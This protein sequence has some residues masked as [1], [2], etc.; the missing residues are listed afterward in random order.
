MRAH[1]LV[2]KTYSA[3]ELAAMTDNAWEALVH[4]ATRHLGETPVTLD[5]I[6][7]DITTLDPTQGRRWTELGWLRK[8]VGG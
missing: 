3:A 1:A 4:S 2:M 6:C 5:I 7:P 8:L